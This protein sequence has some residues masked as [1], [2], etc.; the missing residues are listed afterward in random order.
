VGS[1]NGATLLKMSLHGFTNLTG[2][3]PFMTCDCGAIGPVRLLRATLQD[4]DSQ[5]DLV[6]FNHSLEHMPDPISALR[7]ARERLREG[8][9]VLVRLPVADS[10]ADRRFGPDWVALDAPRHFFIPSV[11]GF[12]E[13]ARRS[14]LRVRRVFFDSSPLQFWGSALYR[15]G[16]SLTAALAEGL[17]PTAP[18]NRNNE[19]VVRWHSLARRLNACGLGDTAGFQLSV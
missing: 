19:T 3:D 7:Q 5:F 2:I 10:Y 1:G 13:L 12:R 6:M 4:L 18:A 15:E 8:G 14:G 11:V 9:R 17:S 16:T